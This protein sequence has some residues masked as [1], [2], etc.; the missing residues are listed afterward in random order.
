ME[1]R[2]RW[3]RISRQPQLIL[4]SLTLIELIIHVQNQFEATVPSFSWMA[5][6][7][8][9]TTSQNMKDAIACYHKVKSKVSTESATV[10]LSGKTWASP[11]LHGNLL[12]ECHYSWTWTRYSTLMSLLW[13]WESKNRWRVDTRGGRCCPRKTSNKTRPFTLRKGFFS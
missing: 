12:T 6:L 10:C 9:E 11:H 4:S 2:P 5:T 8:P 1:D 13:Q 3:W 7:Q